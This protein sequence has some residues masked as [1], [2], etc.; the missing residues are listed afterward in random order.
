M[1]IPGLAVGVRRLH[2]AGKSGWMYLVGL[3]P[4]AGF[5]WLIV[6]WAKEGEP[7]ENKWGPNPNNIPLVDGDLLRM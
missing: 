7:G 4:L 1:L 6:L 5:I 2:D 3:I